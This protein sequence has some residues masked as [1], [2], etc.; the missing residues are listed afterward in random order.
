MIGKIPERMRSHLYVELSYRNYRLL[1]KMHEVGV[2][3]SF[4]SREG[5]RRS[6]Q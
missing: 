6:R 1:K 2:K 3:H 4:I 5:G